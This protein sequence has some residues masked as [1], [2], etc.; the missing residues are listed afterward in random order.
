MKYIKKHPIIKYILLLLLLGGIL[1]IKPIQSSIKEAMF[2]LSSLNVD[3]VR[4][5]ILS[6]GAL[7]P[8][9]SFLLMVFQSI[10]APLPAFMITFAN[11]GLFGWVKGALLSWTSSMVGAAL[12]FYIARYFGRNL[13]EKL[14]S[15]FALESVDGFFERYGNYAVVVARL[16]PFISFDI[17]SYAAGLTSMSFWKF[18]IATGIGQLPATIVYSYVGG[19]LV[20]GTKML[21]FGLLILFALTT[22]IFLFKRIY[23]DKHRKPQAQE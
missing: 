4:G 5:Y 16:L 6:Y 2:I 11:A 23:D 13:V 9:I 10:I 20:G 12:C 8:V 22:T 21:V 3:I 15:K 18:I 17:V 14:T 1:T 7:A 19:M